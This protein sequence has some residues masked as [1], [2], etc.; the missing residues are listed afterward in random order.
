MVASPPW[1]TKTISTLS[2]DL[3]NFSIWLSHVTAVITFYQAEGLLQEDPSTAL[4]H[5]L[6]RN[7][8]LF[9]RQT[10]D[11]SLHSLITAETSTTWSALQSLRPSDSEAIERLQYRIT[12]I[13][14]KNT[15]AA[16]YIAAHRTA[17]GELVKLDATHHYSKLSTYH[18]R[19]LAGIKDCG[20]NE[21]CLVHRR[22]KAV[23]AV[24]INDLFTDIS[25]AFSSPTFSA[26]AVASTTKHPRSFTRKQGMPGVIYN[27]KICRMDN[28]T[29][30]EHTV[31]KPPRSRQPQAGPVDAVAAA[32]QAELATLL[33]EI[34]SLKD[35]DQARQYTHSPRILID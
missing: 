5:A 25:E 32:V 22:T 33:A 13:R 4:N 2:P 19:I 20:M 17:H 35:A 30:D 29:T 28:H 6:G 21:V 8:T 11:P 12:E 1:S 10:T 24:T 26:A 27:C 23:T 31:R 3:S 16:A 34:A 7:L 18:Q 15:T 14:L 9:L